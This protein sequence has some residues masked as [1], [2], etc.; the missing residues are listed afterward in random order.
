MARRRVW[1]QLPDPSGWQFHLQHAVQGP[2]RDLLLLPFPS[3]SQG[4]RW[5]WWHQGS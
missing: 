4:S 5:L 3:I 1:Y 2:N